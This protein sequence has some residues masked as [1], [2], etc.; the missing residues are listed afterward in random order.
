M[1]VLVVD[2][3]QLTLQAIGHCLNQEGYYISLSED[4]TKALHVLENEKIDLIISD[5]MMPHISGLGFLSVLKEFYFGKIPV[6]L[7]SSLDKE[8][9]IANSHSLGADKF[10]TKP[11][12]MKELLQCVNTILK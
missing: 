2:D 10:L 3:D 6:I 4:V 1:K 9:V 5:I 11:I 7:I 8:D 12:D